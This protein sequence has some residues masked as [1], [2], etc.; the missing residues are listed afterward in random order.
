[1]G[2]KNPLIKQLHA[3]KK[4]AAVSTV[5]L[6]GSRATGKA[7]SYSDVDLIVVSPAF[8][9]LSFRWRATKMYDYWTLPYPVDFLC[10]T[11]KEF[12]KFRKQATIVREAVEH[13][14]EIN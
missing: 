4:A 8:K 7:G 14:I 9:G 2:K 13:G 12:N 3:F 1:M 6:F 10:Y 11:P 5:I